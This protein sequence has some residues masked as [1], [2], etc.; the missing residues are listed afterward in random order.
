[1][2]VSIVDPKGKYWFERMRLRN[3]IAKLEDI[4]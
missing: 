2:L 1:L 3:A 4:T